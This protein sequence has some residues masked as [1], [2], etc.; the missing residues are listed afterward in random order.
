MQ[1]DCEERAGWFVYETV[2]DVSSF[3]GNYFDGF[4]YFNFDYEFI[5]YMD[6]AN[7]WFRYYLENDELQKKKIDFPVS[8]FGIDKKI[9]VS[10]YNIYSYEVK[11]YRISDSKTLAVNRRLIFNGGWIV[12]NLGS[13]MS[14]YHSSCKENIILDEGM[15]NSVLSP[16]AN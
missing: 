13:L 8:E 10:P 5:E 16:I 1:R 4:V 2:G 15:V 14:G 3:S 9:S 6:S 7:R 11:I 12:S